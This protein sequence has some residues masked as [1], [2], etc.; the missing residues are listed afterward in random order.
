MTISAAPLQALDSALQGALSELL[1]GGDFEGK[2]GQASKAIRLMSAGKHC[3]E[4]CY[5]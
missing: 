3:C 5:A 2:Q 4:G 1:S